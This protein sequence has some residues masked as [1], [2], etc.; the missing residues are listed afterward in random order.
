MGTFAAFTPE[1]CQESNY[2]ERLS[3]TC[4]E[5]NGQLRCEDRDRIECAT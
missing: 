2:L 5:G 3:E 4:F 1:G